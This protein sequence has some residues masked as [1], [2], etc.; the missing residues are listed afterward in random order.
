MGGKCFE[1]AYKISNLNIDLAGI[2]GKRTKYQQIDIAQL[3]LKI[4]KL[5]DKND[6]DFTYSNTNI[7]LEGLPKVI[8]YHFHFYIN[9]IFYE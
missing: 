8:Y 3:V 2:K 1:N 4:Q 7:T 6:S 9:Y 5:N